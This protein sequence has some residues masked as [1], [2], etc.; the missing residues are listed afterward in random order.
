MRTAAIIIIAANRLLKFTYPIG[1]RPLSGVPIRIGR[2]S[3]VLASP[4]IISHAKDVPNIERGDDLTALVTLIDHFDPPG[5]FE[6]AI[7][8]PRLLLALQSGLPRKIRSQGT[9]VTVRNVS[10]EENLAVV[11][12]TTLDIMRRLKDTEQERSQLFSQAEQFGHEVG[13]LRADNASLDLALSHSQELCAILEDRVH[14]LQEEEVGAQN[15]RAEELKSSLKEQA[16]RVA[17]LSASLQQ[18]KADTRAKDVQIDELRSDLFGRN[19]LLDSLKMDLESK[20]ALLDTFKREMAAKD[21]LLSDLKDDV[22]SKSS[23][24]SDLRTKD[25]LLDTLKVMNNRD[26]KHSRK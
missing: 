15:I 25:A 19:A 1:Q 21:A 20:D 9:V 11:R 26:K 18:L 6:D 4:V 3:F 14:H 16:T 12:K 17:E 22:R 23:L 7:L 8:D 13:Q 24:L 2:E 10:T 5:R